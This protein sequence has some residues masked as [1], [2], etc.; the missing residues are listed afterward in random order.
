[1]IQLAEKKGLLMDLSPLQSTSGG[2]EMDINQR[3]LDMATINGK[4]LMLP[5]A[6]FPKVIMYNKGFFDAANI[7]YPQGDWTWEQFRE[8]SEKIKTESGPGSALTY[9]PFTFDILMGSTGKHILSPKG[10]TSVGY[11]DSPEAIST[12]QWLNAYYQ[13]Y[14]FNGF[15]QAP[16]KDPDDSILFGNKQLGMV[17]TGS[18]SRYMSFQGK[19]ELGTA[20]IPYFE[21][22]KRASWMGLSGLSISQKSEHPEEAWKFIEYLTL[23]SNEDSVQFAQ[24]GVLTSKTVADAAGQSSDPSMNVNL[25]EMNYVEK[26]SRNFNPL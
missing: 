10:D 18:T 2:K 12:I 23:I 24:G 6:A 21:S 15:Q 19:E 1:M 25:D 20:P 5:Y 11:L 26:S 14:E 13:D 4:L 9:D 22:G 7:P 16:L 17:L 8:I 3:I